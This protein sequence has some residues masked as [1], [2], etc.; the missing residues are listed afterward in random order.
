M[1]IANKAAN[2]LRKAQ[3]H[4]IDFTVLCQEHAVP[5]LD[6]LAAGLVL[7]NMA[8]EFQDLFDNLDAIFGEEDESETETE[9]E[10]DSNLTAVVE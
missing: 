5:N 7:M 6:S 4:L 3:E 10:L 2:E 1:N 8:L 9:A